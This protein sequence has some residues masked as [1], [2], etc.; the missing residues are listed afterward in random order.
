MGWCTG[1]HITSGGQ[2]QDPIFLPQSDSQD[3]QVA[4][5]TILIF[6][7]GKLIVVLV[8]G[9]TMHT[10]SIEPLASSHR[11]GQPAAPNGKDHKSCACTFPL[12]RGLLGNFAYGDVKPSR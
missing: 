9:L 12:G 7:C 5:P 3:P 1:E 10:P 8:G 6:L 2:F 11:T 4:Y